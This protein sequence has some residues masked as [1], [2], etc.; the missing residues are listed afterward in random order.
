MLKLGKS[1]TKW[2]KLVTLVR[3]KQRLLSSKEVLQVGWKE[4]D[5]QGCGEM[6]SRRDL[7]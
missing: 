7:M 2:D 5:G 6:D 1:Q 3:R 4:G